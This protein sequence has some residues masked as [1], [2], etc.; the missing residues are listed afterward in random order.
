MVGKDYVQKFTQGTIPEDLPAMAKNP[1]RHSLLKGTKFRKEGLSLP[2]T[3]LIIGCGGTVEVDGDTC[4][5]ECSVNCRSL[6]SSSLFDAIERI[7][8]TYLQFSF[9]QAIAD[10]SYT[11]TAQDVSEKEAIE[12]EDIKMVVFYEQIK[13]RQ[14]SQVTANIGISGTNFKRFKKSQPVRPKVECIG[15]ADMKP[16]RSIM[17]TGVNSSKREAWLETSMPTPKPKQTSVTSENAKPTNSMFRSSFFTDG[18]SF[19]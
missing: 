6:S 1:M 13:R 9:V 15:L 11:P 7:D 10:S 18:L 5:D 17:E 2:M 12:R 16:Y 14:P 8:C 19:D 3:L 4:I